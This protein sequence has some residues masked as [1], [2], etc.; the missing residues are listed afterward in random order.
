MLSGLLFLY[1]L[2]VKQGRKM[3]SDFNVPSRMGINVRVSQKALGK[4][5]PMGPHNIYL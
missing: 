2:V 3:N 4:V 5:L 1:K